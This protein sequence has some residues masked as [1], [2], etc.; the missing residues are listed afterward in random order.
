MTKTKKRQNKEKAERFLYRLGVTLTI[1]LV[2]GIVS[3]KSALARINLEV[4]KLSD[5]VNDKKE[6]NQS[7]VMKI[8]EMASLENIQSVSEDMGLAY[9]NDNIKT[10]E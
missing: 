1:F 4:Q 2:I 9:N 5:E 7:L 8:N 10:I 3:G 6:E